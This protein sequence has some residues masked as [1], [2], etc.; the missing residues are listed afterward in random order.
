MVDT[1]RAEAALRDL[2]AAPFAKQH[3]RCGHAHVFQFDFHVP[4]RRIVIPKNGQMAQHRD[5]FRVERYQDHRLLR[6]ALGGKIRLAHHDRDLAARIA[7]AG[8]PPF[9]TV[10]DVFVAILFDPRF[11][12]GGVRTGGIRLGHQEGGTDLAIHQRIQPLVLLLARAVAMEN[13]HIAGIG[14]G[15]VEDFAG[16]ADA[17]HFFRAHGVFEI[18]KAGAFEFEAFI[19]MV[20]AVVARRHEEVPETL[21]LGFGLQLLDHRDHLP[22]LALG[23]LFQI[24]GHGRAD[25]IGDEALHAIAPIGLPFGGFEIHV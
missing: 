9:A 4:V 22:A 18:G 6:V 17:A 10:D 1:A 20:V 19:D 3:V 23:I 25:V 11:D 16:E 5:A 24:S 14:R 12:I 8:G 21:R 2:E 13:F 15:A 7:H